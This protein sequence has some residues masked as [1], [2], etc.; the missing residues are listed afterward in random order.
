MRRLVL[1]PVALLSFAFAP[2]PKPKPTDQ[3]E[4][5]R[6]QGKWVLVAESYGGKPTTPP[7]LEAVFSGRRLVLG[8]AKD[9]VGWEITL[10]PKASPRAMDKRMPAA[11]KG[12][13][14]LQKAAYSLE[15]D[16]L[17]LCYNASDWWARPKDLSGK[18]QSHHLRVFKRKSP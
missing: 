17:K 11:E 16:T 1:I 4:L 8:P 5:G 3:V 15:G 7:A 14:L 13:F 6:L 9:A 18:G 10:D 12:V 2:V